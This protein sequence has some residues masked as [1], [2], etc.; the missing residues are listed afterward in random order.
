VDIE[1]MPRVGPHV[2]L[3]ELAPLFAPAS[4]PDLAGW[5]LLEAALKADGRGV[6]VDVAKVQVGSPGSGRL[7]GSR[8]VLIPGRAGS[9]DA[10]VVPGPDGFVLSAAVVPVAGAHSS[11]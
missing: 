5:T 11:G 8:A 2:R 7:P 9:V 6:T 10:G 4:P 3:D 1:R